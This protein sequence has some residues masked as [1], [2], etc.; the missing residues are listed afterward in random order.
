MVHEHLRDRPGIET[1]SEGDEP[2]RCV[3]VAPLVSSEPP[4]PTEPTCRAQEALVRCSSCWPQERASVSSVVE[5]ATAWKV[6]VDDSLTGLEW[7]RSTRRGSPI[8]AP[9][10]GFPGLVLAVAL[11]AAGVD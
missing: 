8:S 6:H 5:P 2:G 1:Y 4:S 10:P 7:S 3:V 9:A 11:P